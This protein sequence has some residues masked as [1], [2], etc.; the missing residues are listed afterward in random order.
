[1]IYNI[2]DKYLSLFKNVKFGDKAIKQIK[3]II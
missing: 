1:M 2:R 3:N